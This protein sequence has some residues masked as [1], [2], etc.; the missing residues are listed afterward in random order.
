M[1]WVALAGPLS[2]VLLFLVGLVMF[3]FF[4]HFVGVQSHKSP[5]VEVFV[6]FLSI[7]LYLAFF[8]MLPL[9]PLDG[10]K[11]FERFLP[12]EWNRWLQTHQYELNIALLVLIFLG[13]LRYMALPVH[14]IINMSVLFVLGGAS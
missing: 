11:V 6:I 9:H 8:N 4:V 7:N 5:G 10:G 14:Y 3:Y 1:F 2:N 13:G 12:Y